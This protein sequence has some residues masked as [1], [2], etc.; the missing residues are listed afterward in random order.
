MN[1][2]SFISQEIDLSG[3]ILTLEVGRYAGQ[4]SGAVVARLGDTV[5]LATVVAGREN[6]DIGYLPLS[7]EYQEKLYSGGKIKG[8]RWVKREG[9]P[10]DEAILTARLIDRSLRPLFPKSLRREIQVVVTTLSVDAENDPDTPAIVAVSAALGLTGLPF[11][12]PVGAVRVGYVPQN[13][14]GNFLTNPTYQDREYSDLDLIVSGN[15]DGIVMVE[16]GGRELSEA[17]TILAIRHGHA[18]IIKIIDAIAQL[19][20]K[21][22]KTPAPVD[23]NENQEIAALAK[24][25][26]KNFPKELQDLVNTMAAK[27]ADA[28]TAELVDIISQKESLE[29]KNLVASALDKAA[30]LLVRQNIL[31]TGLRP[32]G[33][34]PEDIRPIAARVSELPR[35][36][37]SA[38]FQRGTTQALTIT[39]LASPSM[40]QWIESPEHEEKKRYIHHYN[41]PPFSVGETGRMGW[42]S[43][44][45]IGH[46]ALAERALVPVIPAEKD[47][48]YTIRVVSEIMSS[49]GSTSMA[50]V[51]GST[52]SLMDA[53]VPIKA[54]VAGIAMGLVTDGQ[55]N[56]ILSD[57]AGIEDFKGDMDFKV[58]GTKAGIT[59]LQMDVK[60]PGLSFDIL[61]AALEQARVGR[62]SILEKMLAVLPESKREVSKYAPKI[63]ILQ[64][65]VEKIGDVIG[66]GGKTIKKIIAETESEIDVEDDGTVVVSGVDHDKIQA[67]VD[68][69]KGLTKEIKIGEEYDG[70]VVR[71][72]DFGA[73]VNLIPG[74]DG[75]VHVSKLS[76]GYL[77]HP[78][79]VISEGR[80]LKVRV[81]NIDDQGRVSLL[82]VA[83]LPAPAGSAPRPPRPHDDRGRGPR[84]FGPRPFGRPD[85]RRRRPYY[86]R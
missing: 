49:N 61:A 53:G 80:P 12:G 30:T 33:R 71:I 81:D 43:R 66:P 86:E 21:L 48:P 41:M 58:A 82:P 37:G 83:P 75:L 28:D 9:R 69:I 26:F 44:R 39:T 47:F 79:E 3:K 70:T 8:S 32:D 29:D 55:K 64:I 73:F 65:D 34:K 78:S 63:V 36:H 18:E 1:T 16:A 60:V 10:S 54:P 50:S 84:P 25:I 17:N 27:E 7:V 23:L 46:G 19:R 85:Q 15:R 35:T 31:E 38:M 40:E 62:L 5:V 67:A 56:V 13:G 77:S 76:T 42:P 11:A 6:P 72:T 52:L 57:I 51:C 4:A 45:E 22:G 20:Q 59:A 14:G 2:S 24:K 74:K 68:W